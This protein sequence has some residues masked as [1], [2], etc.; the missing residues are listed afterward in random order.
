MPMMQKAL[1]LFQEIVLQAWTA[2]PRF[3]HTAKT[4]TWLYRIALN[5]AISYLRKEKKQS[6]PQVGIDKVVLP[7]TIA[8]DRTEE[9]KVMH[10]MIALLPPLEK[11]LILLYLD[12][13]NHL[14]IADILGITVSNVSTR[15]MRIREKLK[16][17]VKPL[18]K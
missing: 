2:Y 9:F 12:D 3:N 6:K 16:K 18:F 7:N 15:L 17:Q 13:K 10:N 14:E 4:S 5:T 11:A 8:D 1:N